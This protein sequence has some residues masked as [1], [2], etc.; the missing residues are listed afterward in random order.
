MDD[1]FNEL[2]YLPGVTMSGEEGGGE[3]G[4]GADGG[5]VKGTSKRPRYT[6]HANLPF[7]YIVHD[8]Q[9]YWNVNNE[10]DIFGSGEFHE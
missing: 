3:G 4:V 2:I 10:L 5:G 9:K 8:L 7:L 1:D 6:S